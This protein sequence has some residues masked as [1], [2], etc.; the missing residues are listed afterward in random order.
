[1]TDLLEPDLCVIG[2][3]SGG[4]SVAS[5]GAALGARVVLIE[6]GTMGG[7]CL[8]NGCVPSKTLL[9]SA[10]LAKA[11]RNAGRLGLHAPAPDADHAEI[12]ARIRK[13]IAEIAPTDSEARF[14]AMN[15][16]VIRASARFVARDMVEAG[17]KRIKA[18]R[19][20]LATG[21]S[22]E[23]PP[24][25]GLELVRW[26]TNETIF[27]LTER[28]RRLLILGGG[29]VGIELAQGFRR[30]GS[31]VVVLEATRILAREDRELAEVVT[32]TLLREGVD[33]RVGARVVA[34]E[35][36][37]DGVRLLLEGGASLEG[38]HLLLA[39]GRRANVEGLG[40]EAAG[41]AF[42]RKGVKV[43]RNLRT[44]NR[45]VFA[46]GDV[47]GGLQFTH[48]ANYQAGIVLRAALF[49]LPAKVEDHL[50]PRVTYTDP[51]I[52]VCG[53]S[54]EDAR[55]AHGQIHVLRSSFA[56]NDRAQTEGETAG[57]IKV[58]TTRNGRVLGA[59]IVGARAGELIALWQLAVTKGI[60][61]TEIASLVLPYPT[62]SEISKRAAVGALTAKLRNPWLGRALKFARWLG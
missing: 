31:E 30:L 12:H 46:V 6:R 26:L 9:A 36:A 4:L 53:L 32:D 19:F 43:R 35:P 17:G 48:A 8:N 57:H 34:V 18:R 14:T 40:L 56:E 28:P 5:A 61:V 41:V 21:S 59:G 55:A 45:R 38:S 50:V 25:P 42:D 49:R 2:A 10:H 24:I 3:G 1:M 44:T 29:P 15:I 11:M 47:T 62:L 7:E 16:N 22:P 60:A 52:A 33:L 51:E 13:V 39:T 23:I 27:D 37:G 58:I 54:E 20:V